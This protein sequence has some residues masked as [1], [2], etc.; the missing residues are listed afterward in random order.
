MSSISPSI[1]FKYRFPKALPS[2]VDESNRK[3]HPSEDIAINWTKTIN[4]TI[5]LNLIRV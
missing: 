1:L 5:S 3:K 2:N 4:Y